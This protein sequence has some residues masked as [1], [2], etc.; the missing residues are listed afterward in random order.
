FYL[1]R[2]GERYAAMAGVAAFA[3]SPDYHGRTRAPGVDGGQDYGFVALDRP[4]GDQF[5]WIEVQTPGA[6]DFALAAGAGRQVTQ[7]GYSWD[8]GAAL[9]A[10]H[11]C[12]VTAFLEDNAI[13]HEC[14][15]TLGDSGSPLFA[16][17]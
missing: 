6:E 14:D 15:T 4:L 13:F 5:G 16:E 3:A 17:L 11:G 10:H 7:G 2:Q 9:S 12:R 8:S 1:G